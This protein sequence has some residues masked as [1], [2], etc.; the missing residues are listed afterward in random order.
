MDTEPAA[1]RRH[2]YVPAVGPR[3]RKVLFV[4]FG[5]FA[6]LATNS[7]YLV[8][9]TLLEWATGRTYQNW[10][11]MNMFLVHLML[12]ALILLPVIAFGIAHISNAHSR[13]N[14]RAVRVGYGLFAT[15]L[16]P[17]VK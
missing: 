12:G 15:A 5:L 13:P 9:V 8:G 6:L 11:Y 14:R 16:L 7:L 17:R 1:E 4:A 2:K 3:L 10:F